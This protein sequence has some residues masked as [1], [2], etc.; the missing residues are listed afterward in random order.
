MGGRKPDSRALVQQLR[1]APQERVR[2]RSPCLEHLPFYTVLCGLW[3]VLVSP[4]YSL[5][6]P[7]G[8]WGTAAVCV[9]EPDTKNVGGAFS[10]H[11]LPLVC[12]Q[13]AGPWRGNEAAKRSC[14]GK[15]R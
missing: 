1:G 8:F 15:M 6:A 14:F 5:H 13:V 12:S 7:G 2:T 3:R 11:S 10:S 4:A 9:R